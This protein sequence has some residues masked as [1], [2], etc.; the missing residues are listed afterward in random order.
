MTSTPPFPG[1]ALLH[2]TATSDTGSFSLQFYTTH[3]PRFPSHLRGDPSALLQTPPHHHPQ[4]G[5]ALASLRTLLELSTA[6]S[7]R[8]PLYTDE[9]H[10]PGVPKFQITFNFRRHS[11]TR[12][13]RK[14]IE[15]SAAQNRAPDPESPQFLPFLGSFNGTTGL[16]SFRPQPLPFSLVHIQFFTK[17]CRLRL[18][19]RSLTGQPSPASTSPA[20]LTMAESLYPATIH[21]PYNSQWSSH[22]RN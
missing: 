4:C 6:C 20:P 11:Y 1:L 15:H 9:A 8:C 10:S 16:S 14:Y 17:L 18:Q 3:S 7:F 5:L 13:P 2:F 12:T 19:N 21:S 22:I